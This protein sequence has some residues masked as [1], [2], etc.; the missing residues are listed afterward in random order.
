MNIIVRKTKNGLALCRSC[1]RDIDKGELVLA[2][3]VSFAGK[4]STAMYCSDHFRENADK[5]GKAHVA[6][7]EAILGQ[8]TRENL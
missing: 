5:I 3:S 4:S 6:I 7:V 8:E 1:N 2:I